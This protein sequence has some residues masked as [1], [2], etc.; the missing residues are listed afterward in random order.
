VGKSSEE[1]M[2]RRE[3]REDED[4][5][6]IKKNIFFIINFSSVKIKIKNDIELK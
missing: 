3:K 4:I 5:I 1:K 2:K 6:H